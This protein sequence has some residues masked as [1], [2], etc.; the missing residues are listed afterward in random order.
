MYLCYLYKCIDGDPEI[1]E[2]CRKE[3]C[4]R[5]WLDVRVRVLDVAYHYERE[6]EKGMLSAR[7]HVCFLLSIFARFLASIYIF[8]K[9]KSLMLI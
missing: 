7:D 1:G 9:I 8:F 2:N 3:A 4:T 5:L 6:R